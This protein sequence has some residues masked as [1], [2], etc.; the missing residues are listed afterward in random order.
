MNRY[1][2]EV[3]AVVGLHQKGFVHDFQFDGTDLLWVQEKI[4]IERDSFRMLE[5]YVFS[6]KGNEESVSAIYGVL[7]MEHNI[8]GILI[9]HYMRS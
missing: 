8:R 7:A 5:V 1:H 9:D 2:S 4:S 6:D 3:E